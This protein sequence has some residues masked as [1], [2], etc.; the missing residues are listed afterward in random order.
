MVLVI[1]LSR[2]RNPMFQG[3]RWRLLAS[4]LIVMA[5]ILG[6]FGAGVYSFFSRKFYQKIDEQLLILAQSAAPSLSDIE[7]E[8]RQYLE[9]V[10]E[11]PWR[12]IFNRDLQSLEWFNAEGNLIAKKGWLSIDDPPNLGGRNM[13]IRAKKPVQIRIFTIQVHSRS[14]EPNSPALQGYIRASQSTADLRIAQQRLLWGLS[15]GGTIALGLVGVG[16]LWLTE[17]A[18]KPIEQSF[19][20]LKQFTADASHELRGPL[21]VIKTSVDVMLNHPERFHPQDMKKLAV[22]SGATI[23]INQLVEDL[24]FLARTDVTLAAPHGEWGPVRLDQVLGE[25]IQIVEPAAQAKGI[26]LKTQ[27]IEP[28]VITG[29]ERQLSR[30]FANLLH[31]ALQYTLAGGVVS[32]SVARHHQM[33]VI[34]VQDTGIGIKREHLPRV[35][36][37]FWRAD[38][39]R[40][41]RE[42]G[43]G[44]GLAISQS[45]ANLYQGKITLT[46]QEGVGSCFRVHLPGV[47][48]S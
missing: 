9:Q 22:V 29:D 35:F 21:T 47:T 30:L 37:R 8:G 15:M 12:N 44:L 5:A 4:Y 38:Q 33:T 43:L 25:L 18:L 1:V 45:I 46:S 11:V 3:L 6:T 13:T 34:S 48:F 31:N 14:S 36:D 7:Q 32:L 26:T 20:R 42:S 40:T 28:M 2:I 27:G 23:Q 41:H 16:G 17:K 39:A 19:L 24:L 10:D